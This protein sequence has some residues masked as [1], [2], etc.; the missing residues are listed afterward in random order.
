MHLRSATAEGAGVHDGSFVD[1]ATGTIDDLDAERTQLINDP[2]DAIVQEL[3]T[4]DE[5]DPSPKNSKPLKRKGQAKVYFCGGC[6]KI[7][8]DNIPG[9]NFIGCEGKC[10]KWFHLNCAGLTDTDYQHLL[11]TNAK[12]IC[13]TCNLQ[14]EPSPLSQAITDLRRVAEQNNIELNKTTD[15]DVCE[16]LHVITL[17]E[18]TES[19]SS[20]D[21]AVWGILRGKEIAEAVNHAYSSIVRWKKNLFKVY[22]HRKSWP[23]VYRRS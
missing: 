8:A 6:H 12:W 23:R 17:P 7:L 3:L 19:P 10:P 5:T 20:I 18:P 21:Q 11:D 16:E 15:Q 13:S 2:D 1:I 9:Q 14:V 4:D 22:T